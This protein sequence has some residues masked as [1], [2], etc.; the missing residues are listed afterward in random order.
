[1]KPFW[2]RSNV[3]PADVY[4]PERALRYRNL[5]PLAADAKSVGGC[6][7]LRLRLALHPQ[8]AGKKLLALS[9]L[10]FNDRAEDHQKI[11]ALREFLLAEKCEGILLAGDG[12]GDAVAIDA[13]ADALAPLTSA[14]KFAVASPGNWEQSKKWISDS[15]WHA[16]YREAGFDL[17]CNE[18]RLYGQLFIAGSR[19]LHFGVPKA[20]PVP[21]AAH[22]AILLAHSAD[23]VVYLDDGDAL[24]KYRLA[25][26]GHFHGGQV[27][28]PF[29]PPFFLP[30]CYGRRF[31]AGFFR[32][33]GMPLEM[34]ILRGAGELS[35]PWRFNSPREIALIELI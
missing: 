26:T 33:A 21:E 29:L 8:L 24:Q 10:H 32:R 27:R 23:A 19:D 1:L 3:F 20:I 35:F 7:V 25:I 5:A 28:L 17:L 9:D 4:H 31:A 18:G 15:L 12:V 11:A 16:L 14:V 22:G 13:F 30:S 34:M 6:R 2:Q